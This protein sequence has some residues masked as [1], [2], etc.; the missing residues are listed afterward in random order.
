MELGCTCVHVRHATPDAAA[1]KEVAGP[2]PSGRLCV[3]PGRVGQRLRGQ[4]PHLLGPLHAAVLEEREGRLVP[5]REIEE[6]GKQVQ[7][8]PVLREAEP[9]DLMANPRER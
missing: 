6:R 1:L 3:Q 7:S 5:L 2:S 4:V 8:D 9:L